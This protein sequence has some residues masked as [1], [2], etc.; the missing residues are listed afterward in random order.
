MTAIRVTRHCLAGDPRLVGRT[1][2]SGTN[3]LAARPDAQR[4]CVLL[5]RAPIDQIQQRQQAAKLASSKQLE[6]PEEG[7]EPSQPC[8]HWI[9][10]RAPRR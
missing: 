7:L 9:L 10:S 5:N 4:Q 3:N 8:G 1:D 6:L 2:L